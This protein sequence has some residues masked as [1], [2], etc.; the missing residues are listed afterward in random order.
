M[1]AM[2]AHI[3]S[4]PPCVA[5]IDIGQA[6]NTLAKLAALFAVHGDAFRIHSD[7][8]GRDLFV[9][10]HP[11]HVRHVLVD[12]ASNYVKGLG[13]ERVAIL[14]GKGLMTS[15]GELWRGQRKALQPAFHR[16]A[17][18]RHV[19]AITAANARLVSL[20]TEAAA[21]GRTINLSHDISALT[22]EIV[23]RAI[24]GDDYAG[25]VDQ[26][27][28]FALLTAESDR[29][30]KF[31]YAFRQLGNLL[32]HTL[33][34]RRK[35]RV[36]RDDILQTL[37]AARDRRSGEAMP[38]RQILDEILTLIVAGHETTASALQWFWYLIAQSPGVAD[39]LHHEALAGVES[40]R[41]AEAFPLAR[42]SIAETLRLYPPGWL[43]TR[44]AIAGDRVGDVVIAAGDNI[45]ISPYLV[46]R[47][48][49]FWSDPDGFNPERFRD[50]EQASRSR[51]CYLPFGLGPRA[52]IGEP[53]A[54]VE[55]QIHV[56]AASRELAFTLVTDT[57]IEPVAK[58]NLRPSQSISMR[59][60]QRHQT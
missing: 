26:G 57:P 29:D 43:L 38:N 46:H 13:I 59:V 60:S 17:V 20:W 4:P 16:S 44:R 10:S 53:L 30:L 41:D 15:E 23:L 2:A 1:L 36:P 21:V 54:L 22:L 42:A 6:E 56:V 45:L 40:A 52:C 51:F 49:E 48:P 32:Q 8:L 35:E 18:A 7:E 9:L 37:V 12:R 47:H 28:P 24:F 25:L 3:L 19:D 14:L 33:E 27:N 55:M 58:V 34:Q 5:N 39:A 11:Q 50:P 31:A